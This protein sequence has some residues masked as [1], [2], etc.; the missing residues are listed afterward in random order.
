MPEPINIR[1]SEAHSLFKQSLIESREAASDLKMMLEANQVE[2]SQED[3]QKELEKLAEYT[4]KTKAPQRRA[5]V[6]IEKSKEVSE[7]RLIRKEDADEM[8]DQFSGRDDNK[9]Y[10][11]DAK[12]L[13]LLAFEELGI[14]INETSDPNDI[15]EIVRDRMSGKGEVIDPALLDK[16]LEFLL[17]VTAAQMKNA[18]PHVKERLER[19]HNRIETAK[20]NHYK[21]NAQAIE[22]AGKIIGAVSAVVESTGMT[23]KEVLANYREIVHNPPEL[24]QLR[25]HFESKGY[26]AMKLELKGLSGYLGQNFKRGNIENAELSQLAKAARK[27]QALDGV[28]KLAKEQSVHFLLA[29]LKNN[30]FFDSKIGS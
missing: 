15:V 12:R 8:A 11:L 13:G 10:N 5:K 22:V 24:Q 25:K 28:F 3:L 21:E 1:G 17:F 23:T 30:G 2:G 19:I 20:I 7:S 14:S 6:K 4:I 26:R 16:G 9:A 29:Y 18:V 27:M